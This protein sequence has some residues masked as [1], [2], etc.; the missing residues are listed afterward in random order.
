MEHAVGDKIGQAYD[1]STMLDERR[2]FMI[3]WCDALVEQ[4]FIT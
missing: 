2:E 3:K 4:G 1:H